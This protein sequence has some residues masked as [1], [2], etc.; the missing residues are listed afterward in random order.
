MFLF[1]TSKSDK[2]VAFAAETKFAPGANFAKSDPPHSFQMRRSI[3]FA[4]AGKVRAC[5]YFE[6]ELA[7][8]GLVGARLIGP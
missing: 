6:G 1:H 4:E 7:H 3:A 8:S 2:L 5:A